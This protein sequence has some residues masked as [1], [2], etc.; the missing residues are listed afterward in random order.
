MSSQSNE[1]HREMIAVAAYY[2]AEH[3]GFREGDPVDDW[4]KA[5]AEIEQVLQAQP[6]TAAS[7]K[8]SFQAKL[9]AQLEAWDGKLAELKTKAA[10]SKVKT[11]AEL[12]KQLQGIAILRTEAEGKLAQL[13]KRSDD[14]WLD[15][16]EETAKVWDELRAALDRTVKRFK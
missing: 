10:E 2:R 1:E 3:R 7:T 12:E 13:R 11:R 4:L 8:Q 16:R 5:E 6:G 14:A 9:E 15:L